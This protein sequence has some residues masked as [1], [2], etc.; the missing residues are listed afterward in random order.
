MAGQCGDSPRRW[1]SHAHH[2]EPAAEQ[3]APRKSPS[4]HALEMPQT[5]T[6]APSSPG[7]WLP[8]YCTAGLVCR[9]G[10]LEVELVL[11]Q[12][13]IA[14]LAVTERAI[15]RS[16]ELLH[17]SFFLPPR[18]DRGAI[19]FAE[20]RRKATAEAHP[21]RM[22]LHLNARASSLAYP[23][24]HTDCGRRLHMDRT[25]D[26]LCS[27]RTIILNRG[28]NLQNLSPRGRGVQRV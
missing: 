28:S 1:L 26:P 13:R 18:R 14:H 22:I 23:S 10:L 3:L 4:T 9:R 16:A 6:A 11:D 27:I 5:A 7:R 25:L 19:Q 12:D 20:R 17:P 2:L 24:P 8:S 21:H 15:S